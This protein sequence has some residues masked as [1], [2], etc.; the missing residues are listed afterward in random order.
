MN[1]ASP[2]LRGKPENDDI[3]VGSSP[4]MGGGGE[5]KEKEK[6]FHSE[7]TETISEI[8][9]LKD[10]YAVVMM[11]EAPCLLRLI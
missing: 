6:T 10:S 11:F 8:S 9:L 7:D 2:P 4:I 5:Q 1:V 3:T